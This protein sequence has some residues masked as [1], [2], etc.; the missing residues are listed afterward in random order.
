MIFAQKLRIFMLKWENT[1]L[2]KNMRVIQNSV[3]S[4]FTIICYS[5]QVIN[6]QIDCYEG[7]II[8]Y[9]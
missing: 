9:P 5:L 2:I 7:Y 3:N 6:I 4:S 8:S 1:I